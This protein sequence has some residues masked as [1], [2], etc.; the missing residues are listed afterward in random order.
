MKRAQFTEHLARYGAT[1]ENWPKAL[2]RQ[3][4]TLLTHDVNSQKQLAAEQTFE[5]RLNDW[6][7]G[8]PHPQLAARII[9]ASYGL[10]Q[11]HTPD[12]RTLWWAAAAAL[13]IFVSGAGIGQNFDTTQSG[14][15]NTQSQPY[16]YDDGDNTWTG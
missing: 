3:A 8:T 6:Q 1:L 2:R 15:T 12:P 13:M 11:S 9:G 16:L 7:P 14:A 4:E 5:D 10:V